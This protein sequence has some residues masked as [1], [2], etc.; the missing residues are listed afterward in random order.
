MAT[1]DAKVLQ[2]GNSADWHTVNATWQDGPERE[3]FVPTEQL[4]QDSSGI[5]GHHYAFARE[6][7]YQDVRVRFEFKLTPHSDVGII[8]RARDERSFYLFHMPD[9]G[10]ASRC[11]H[12]WAALSR[13]DESGYLKCVKLDL[14][15]RVPAVP[16]Q[17]MTAEVT[18]QRNRLTATIDDHGYFEAEDDAYMGPGRLGVYATGSG[19][20]RN[21]RVVGEAVAFPDWDDAV[22]QPTNWFYP[23]PREPIWQKPHDLLHLPDGE[24]LLQ[25]VE[26][27]GI[28]QQM[29]EEAR[30]FTTRSSDGGRTWSQ[31]EPLQFVTDQVSA[32][33]PPRLHITPAGRLIA[34]LKQGD[35]YATAESKDGARTWSEPAPTGVPLGLSEVAKFLIGPQAFLNLADGSMLLFAYAKHALG[36]LLQGMQIWGKGHFQ[37]FAFRS[38]DDGRTWSAEVNMDDQGLDNQGRQINGNMDLTEICATQMSDGRVMALIRPLYS[39]WMWETWSDDGGATWGPCLRGPFPGYATPNML[40][41][42]SGAILVA[43]R[44]PTLT[45]NLSWD[46]GHTWDQGTLIDGG[47]WSMGVMIETEPDVV[48]YAYWDSFESLMR[49]QLIR[50][51]PAGLEPIRVK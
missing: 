29:D 34:L 26:Q 47:V 19:Q 9:C 43:H 51:T 44:L 12:F 2:I 33:W 8:M 21:V 32:W 49:A 4:R 14:V 11:Q 1:C 48:L 36:D 28:D 13:M 45:I 37:G 40:R 27:F 50:V 24:I 16:R 38:T 42:T 10:Q 15:R 46:E 30:Q 20:I 17:W 22:R 18:L 25:Y 5:Q 3:L 6:H 35:G 7:C 41:T 31:P 23:V 39:P